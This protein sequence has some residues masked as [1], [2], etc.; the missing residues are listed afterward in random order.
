M[1]T[2]Q[3]NNVE[4]VEEESSVPSDEEDL[5]ILIYQEWQRRKAEAVAAAVK[6]KNSSS[7]EQSINSA[8]SG[9]SP[10]RRSARRKCSVLRLLPE[11]KKKDDNEIITRKGNRKIRSADKST[12]NTSQTGGVYTRHKKAPPS[13]RKKN[14]QLKEKERNP[15]KKIGRKKNGN[16]CSVM[17]CATGAKTGGIC[18]RHG[19]KVKRCCYEGCT[20]HIINSGVCIRHGAKVTRCSYEG[21]TTQARNGGVCLR[22]GAK[23]KR[24][25]YE[26]CTN[27]IINSGVC[28]RHGA[29]VRS[30]M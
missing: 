30:K 11:G 22:H 5:G 23:I 14:L 28:I 1:T 13:E 15:S 29:K 21:C 2:N 27:H 26:G 18:V 16:T 10:L 4:V 7:L 8:I 9:E 12:N 17:G 24:C 19:A 3:N 25:I 20:K 6:N